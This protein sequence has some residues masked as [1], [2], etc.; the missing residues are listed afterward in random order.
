MV[1]KFKFRKNTF[2]CMKILGN[3]ITWKGPV[4]IYHGTTDK[5]Y[6]LSQLTK[7][8]REFLRYRKLDNF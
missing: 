5:K 2:I 1:I 3:L 8:Q 7:L 4:G 6:L